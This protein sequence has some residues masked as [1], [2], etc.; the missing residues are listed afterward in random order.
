MIS[1]FKNLVNIKDSKKPPSVENKMS[2]QDWLGINSIQNNKILLNNGDKVVVLK[3]SP[4]NFKLKSSIEQ[5]SILLSY[6]RFLQNLN[7]K[8]QIVISS[9]KTDVSYHLDKI[10]KFTKEN[11]NLSEVS[12][13]YIKLIKQLIR[14]KSSTTKEFYIVIKCNENVENDILKVIEYLT[15][16]ENEV[17]EC[18]EEEIVSLFRNFANKRQENLL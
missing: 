13:D 15:N 1:I 12:Q 9:K 14:E 5:E 3:V 2:F 7:S 17:E 4:T 16:C 10:Y 18:S 11:P 6:K 8:I